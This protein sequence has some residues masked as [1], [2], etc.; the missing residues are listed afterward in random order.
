MQ[1]LAPYELSTDVV[2]ALI[3]VAVMSD[4]LLFGELHGTQEV[5]RLL[6]RLLDDLA[7]VGYRGLAL[8]IPQDVRNMLEQWAKAESSTVPTFFAHPFADGRGNRQVLALV[9]QVLT[10]EH[11]WHLLCFDQG[12]DQPMNQWADRD[13][14]MAHNL[15]EQWHHLCPQAKIVGICG[16][17]HSRLSLP[18]NRDVTY[19]PSFAHQLQHLSPDRTVRTVKVRFQTGSYFNLK[20]RRLGRFGWGLLPLPR[21]VAIRQSVDHSLE[22]ILPIASPAT[23]LAAPCNGHLGYPF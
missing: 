12:H 23:F 1:E 10:S 2:Q 16:N 5:P 20:R 6:V 4:V 22:L 9:H 11:E 15:R 18:P 8:E 13:G 17:L 19:W 14:W 21:K 7:A 3:D